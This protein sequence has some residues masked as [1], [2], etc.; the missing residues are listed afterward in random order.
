MVQYFGTIIFI[1]GM[2]AGLEIGIIKDVEYKFGGIVMVSVVE[3]LEVILSTVL[4]LLSPEKSAEKINDEKTSKSAKIVL[5]I[6]FTIIY[7]SILIGVIVSLFFISDIP[8]M[9]FASLLIIFL[10]YCLFIFYKRASRS[11]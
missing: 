7:F 2:E 4:N 8:Y 1:L 5:I 9:I 3:L 11:K 6:L 10:L